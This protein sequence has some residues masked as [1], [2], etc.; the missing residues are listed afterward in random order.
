M[1]DMGHGQGDERHMARDV[2]RALGLGVAHQRAD[3]DVPVLARDAVESVDAV[4]IDQQRWMTQPH[5]EGG[6][7][8]L[9]A[10]EEP[11]VRFAAEQLDGV[12]ERPGLGVGEWRW[13]H[14]TPPITPADWTAI[15]F[16]ASDLTS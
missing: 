8:A 9:S 16:T 13:L 5:V 2:G 1:A 7:Q 6:D 10:G 11:G 4:D 14:A 15:I 3:L 12:I